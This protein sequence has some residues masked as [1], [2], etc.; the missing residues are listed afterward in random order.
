MPSGQNQNLCIQQ[1]NSALPLVNIAAA[2]YKLCPDLGHDRQNL[3]TRAV[4][5]KKADP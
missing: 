3:I 1:L 5:W 2:F 4:M